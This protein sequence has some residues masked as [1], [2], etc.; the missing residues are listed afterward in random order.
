MTTNRNTVI[1]I[2]ERRIK[3]ISGRME[4]I[5]EELTTDPKLFIRSYTEEYYSMIQDLDQITYILNYINNQTEND[6]QVISY[7][8]NLKTEYLDFLAR[9]PLMEFSSS[10]MHSLTTLWDNESSQRIIR[11]IDNILLQ[12]PK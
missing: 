12:M 5:Q 11:I 4:T 10:P 6:D 1:N 2:L 7:L 8:N 9:R 3:A